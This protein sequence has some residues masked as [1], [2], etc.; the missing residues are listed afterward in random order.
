MN[1]LILMM[2]EKKFFVSKCGFL[3]Y[4]KEALE[5]KNPEYGEW[6]KVFITK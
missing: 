6:L 1:Y 4:K 2:Q 3:C 5:K